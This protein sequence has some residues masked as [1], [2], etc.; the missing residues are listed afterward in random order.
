MKN[1]FY[2]CTIAL[3]TACASEPEKPTYT[4]LGVNLT[5]SNAEKA[6]IRGN[7]FEKEITV[8]EGGFF[9]DTLDIP[10]DGYYELYIN[11]ERATVY[12]EQGKNLT[13]SLDAIQFDESL[14]FE[15]DLGAENN[16]LAANYL[17]DEKNADFQELY[18][19]NETDFM[20]KA[21]ALNDGLKE[22]LANA[23]STND[24]FI[25]KET[26][27][28]AYEHTANIELYEEYNRYLKKNKTIKVSEGFYDVLGDIDYADTTAFRNSKSYERMVGAHIGRMISDQED[29][30]GYNATISYLKTVDVTLPDGYAKDQLMSNHL[31]YGLTADES[32]NEVYEIY[33]NTNP[34]VENLENLTKR[35][36]LLAT[37]TKGQPSP[38]FEYE[39]FKGGKTSL[40]DLS[41][42]YVYVDV[43]ATWCGP[44]IR[45]IPALKTVEA[46]Y[47]NK[48]IEFV[49]ISI[50]EAKDY[51][52]WKKMIPE[53]ELGGIQLLADTA[54][55]SKFVTDYGIIGIPRFILIDPEGKIVSSDAPRPSDPS[56]RILLD[57]LI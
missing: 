30:P 53:K 55:K 7:N 56:L 20:T 11:R 39:N 24:A 23:G 43:W 2:L 6:M 22:L 35:Y 15:G 29:E 52:K 42:K 57:E 37:L 31:R 28:L 44:C 12:L 14:S 8:P 34:N 27:E 41:G 19:A 40:A 25:Q 18:S 17:Y 16:Y 32:L 46:D 45:E 5:N 21:I 4:V 51:E 26:K 33:K 47:H 48:N 1:L 49:S 50:D 13:L 9:S 36:N 54:W 3:L 10:V 38:T